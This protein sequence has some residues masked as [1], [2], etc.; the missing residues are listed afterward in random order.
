MYVY[1]DEMFKT[2]SHLT[3]FDN[4]IKYFNIRISGLSNNTQTSVIVV[5]INDE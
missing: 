3:I 5:I 2:R 1:H 4:I